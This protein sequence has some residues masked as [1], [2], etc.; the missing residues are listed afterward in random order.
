MIVIGLTGAIA[1]GKSTVAG[2][3]ADLGACVIDADAL[4]RLEMRP[5]TP[6][7]E[8]IR[9][10][11]GPD[12]LA[13]SGHIDRAELG[14]R[15]F[16]DPAALSRLEA[17]VHPAVLDEAASQMHALEAKGCQV[18]V[19][20]AIKLLEA[21]MHRKCDEVWVVTA[22]REQQVQRLMATRSLTRQEAELRIDAQPAP[23]SRLARATVVIDNSGCPDETRQA[24][25]REWRRITEKL[26]SDRAHEQSGGGQMNLRKW[27]DAHPGFTMWAALAVGMVIIFWFTSGDAGM[28]L[29][30]RLFVALACVLLAGLCTW[31][32]NWE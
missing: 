7:Y 6:I 11:F 8:Q 4:S 27:I 2:L 18:L 31:I 29:S 3:L 17:I 20:E 22:P 21:G 12:I 26:A 15:V 16:A 23:E 19:L 25:E 24:V 5:G 14:A 10:E 13:A 28:R 1:A 9:R 30:Q 32:V